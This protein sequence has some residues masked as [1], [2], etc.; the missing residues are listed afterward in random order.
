LDISIL[1]AGDTCPIGRNLPLFQQGDAQSLCGG[2]QSEFEHADLTIVNL[3]CSL[4]QEESPIEKVGPNLGAP[5]DC[6]NGLKMIGIDIVGLANNHIMDHGPQGLRNTIKALEE[7]RISHVG[8]G[9][10]VNEACKILVRDVKGMRIG[11]LAV[12]EHEFGIAGRNSPGGNPLDII[13]LV[14]NIRENRSVCDFLIVL[15]HGGNEYYPYPR[16]SIMNM[17][18]FLVEEGA[19]TVICQHSHCVGSWEIYNNALIVYGQGNFLFDRASPYDSWYE[20]MLVCLSVSNDKGIQVEFIPFVQSNRQA[21]VRQLEPERRVEFIR[22]LEARSRQIRNPDFIQKQ[23][24]IYCK[25]T[26]KHYLAMLYGNRSVLRRVVCRLGV[27]DRIISRQVH[28]MRLHAMRCESYREAL[29]TILSSIIK[30]NK[31]SEK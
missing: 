11:I 4:I 1:I 17:C 14:R 13:D 28:L 26:K 29:I 16:P 27:I 8:A 6:V 7:N 31:H 25:Q 21:G 19:N 22:T 3:E 24:D 2:L 20:G 5:V 9:E 18:R 30:K 15:L 23:W 12:T 10:N